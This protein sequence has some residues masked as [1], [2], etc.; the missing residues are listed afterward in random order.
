MLIAMA[1]LASPIGIVWFIQR[2]L[3]PRTPLWLVII[4][5]AAV[6]A[7]IGLI[8]YLIPKLFGRS[9]KQR[10]KKMEAALASG[11][12]AGPVSMDLRAA[13]K[14]NNEKF[15]TAIRD[16]RKL[17]ISVYDLPWYIVIGDSG[18]GKTKLIN[19]GGLTFSTGKPEGYQLGTL[20]YNW[21]FTED[22]IFVD[23]AGRLCNPQDDADYRE[24]E[25]FLR[26][27][28]TG[29]KGYPINGALLC[30]SAEHLLQD[31]PEKHE[32]DANTMLERL[33]DMQGKLGVTFATYLVVTK[34]D[35]IVGF[36]QFFDRAERDITIKNQI[37]GWSKPGEFSALYEPERFSQ[38]F[39]G[40]YGRLNELRLRRLND[41]ADEFELGMAY[42]F[43]EEFRHLRDP[44]QTYIRTLF[45]AIK[46]PRA[47]KNLIFRGVY[48]T[49]ATQQGG[50]ILR[51]LSERLGSD[52]AAQFQPLES[53]Y[54]RPRP[55]FVKDLLFRKAFPEQGLVFRNE[56][57]V[58]R[59]RKLA[60]ALMYGSAAV[61]ALLLVLLVVSSIQFGKLIG[62]PRDDATRAP[63]LVDKPVEALTLVGRLDGDVKVLKGS[64]W[65]SI[66]SLGIGADRP[67][68]YLTRI[69]MALFEHSVLHPLLAET[70]RSLPKARV[71]PAAD[72]QGAVPFDQYRGALEEYVGWYGCAG[73]DTLPGSID[74]ASFEKLCAVI[75]KQAP[76]L[77]TQR[78]DVFD[79]AKRYFSTIRGV[80][81]WPNPSRFLSGKRF[82]PPRTI[83]AGIVKLHEYGEHYAVLSEEHPDPVIREWMRLRNRCAQI[84]DAYQA[85][86]AATEAPVQTQ[87][88]LDRFRLTFEE[89]YTKLAQAM[90]E[91]AWRG[92]GSGGFVRIPLLR[93]ALKK[94][95]Q[96]W[97]EYQKALADAYGRCG[98][99]DEPGA[100][101][102]T[103]AI[104]ALIGGDS[105]LRGLDRLLA[106][107][108]QAAGLADRGYFAE[109]FGDSF[110]KI[111]REVDESYAHVLVLK[112]GGEAKDDQLELTDQL[113]G[114][115]RPVLDK[116]HARLATLGAGQGGDT[117]AAWVTGLKGV[118]F[119]DKPDDK[120]GAIDVAV[121]DARWDG[122]KLERLNA[123][124]QDLIR[125]G[126]G[127]VLLRTMETRL[128]QTG[129]LGLAELASEWRSTQRSAYYIPVPAAAEAT[130]ASKESAPPPVA[131]QPSGPPPVVAQ[132]KAPGPVAPVA[133]AGPVAP[134][135]PA[136]T[137][138]VPNFASPD[139]LNARAKECVEL[140]RFLADFGPDFYFSRTTD[141]KPLN[142]RCAEL[143]EAAW[144]R[145]CEGYVQ[146][147]ATAYQ[148]K[149]LAELQR[150]A[151][152]NEHWEKFAGQFQPGKAADAD[153]R[154]A[155]RDEFQP[156]LGE[157]LHATRWAAYLPESGWWLEQQD[158]Y[159][160][161][162]KR[163]V[164][165]IFDAALQSQWS[166]GA[167]ARSAS[168][169]RNTPATIAKP[170]DTLAGDY[171]D[172]WV[173]WC[174]AVGA[175]AKLPRKFDTDQVLGKPPAIPWTDIPTLRGESGLN[176]ERITQQLVESQQK[177]QVLL[178]AELTDI[179]CGVQA[180]YFGD[181]APFGGWPYLEE[182]GAGLTAMETVKLEELTQFLLAV[183][184]A[185]TALAALDQGLPDEPVRQAR[186]AFLKACGEWRSFLGLSAQAAATPLDV[187]IWTEDPVGEPFGQERVDDTAQH[188]Y[189][190]VQLAIGLRLQQAA[191]AAAAA[192]ALDFQT[193]ERGQAR[194]VRAV[195]DWT[196]PPDLQ[197]VTFELV[198]G[199]Q[200]ERQDFHYPKIKP[201]VLGAP[202]PLALC[203]YLH[204]YGRYV[205]GNW[206]LS[207]GVDLAEKFKDAGHGELVSQIPGGKETVGEKF[208][209]RLPA[210]R[211]LPDPIPRLAPA[212][213]AAKAGE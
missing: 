108:I 75:P 49:S 83:R 169:G 22:A 130:P 160:G 90:D 161:A 64:V 144:K 151:R 15:F 82:D 24:W 125:K 25:S 205:D 61:G 28:G 176:D 70:D 23:M 126:E 193:T 173:A 110:D 127:T 26:T 194:S 150:V 135:G 178:T 195:W 148:N 119:P 17:G 111:V 146:A 147:R 69:Q 77:A 158:E 73:Q 174:D 164:G 36:M 67:V 18:C 156:A 30:V 81:D 185:E 74:Y 53:L 117:A 120:A 2:Y 180:Q 182:R 58:L 201:R 94:Q 103:G 3:F 133:P 38:D 79:Q 166:Q 97:L 7:V 106:D 93:D 122:K 162:Q 13:V 213:G 9:A 198:D 202:G 99:H 208:V 121:L 43:P 181:R 171:A 91:C 112:R 207:H 154:N 136:G 124:Y 16:M 1:G 4:G 11:A 71:A 55:H 45:P 137:G 141:A 44:L 20:N 62:G 172:R 42:S 123:T 203:A 152:W 65:P 149:S 170:W 107:S 142:Q 66:L 197:E 190:K 46:N 34:C 41:E 118:L 157:I 210:G 87:E 32:A 27:V 59:N 102:L 115:V 153:P 72:A 5:M 189:Q 139:F 54:P 31:P 155:I 187:T 47:V 48:Y 143:V 21:W 186:R 167:F 10:A 211:N 80:K 29:R 128:Q 92:K 50:L 109:F 37:F 56:Q 95:R 12:E 88:Q 68:Q 40:V 114:T 101:V 175:A 131:K 51:H 129:P 104:T 212:G 206:Y 145:Y 100:A 86:L 138:Q 57:D 85:M 140:L 98:P 6:I 209:I 168:A 33:R 35:K 60:R 204:R 113:R 84:H 132:P 196:R 199:I 105:E 200:P 19:E 192:R 165:A 188:Y 89:S 163:K 183:Q 179:F 177:A 134:V 8:G 116:V 184:R 39:D 96:A 52:A 14:S 76:V 63:G 159:Y 78:Q 191:E